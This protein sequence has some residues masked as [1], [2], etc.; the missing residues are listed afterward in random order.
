M[1]PFPDYGAI[2]SSKTRF[3]GTE[4]GAFLGHLELVIPFR[5]AYEEANQTD[6]GLREPR[7]SLSKA[8]RMKDGPLGTAPASPKANCLRGLTDLQ[9]FR[10]F[11]RVAGIKQ[12]TSGT[13]R[14]WKAALCKSCSDLS[15]RPSTVL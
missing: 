6:F 9:P 14:V 1:L 4:N 3:T 12:G 5:E 13:L 7:A 11:S 15:L 8:M 10:R 2:D